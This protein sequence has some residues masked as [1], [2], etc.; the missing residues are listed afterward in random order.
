M[1]RGDVITSV[2]G[3]TIKD[4]QDFL[5]T[6]KEAKVGQEVLFQVTRDRNPL[7]IRLLRSSRDEGTKR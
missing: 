4:I 7:T 2:D 1:R 3:K 5:T 6:Y